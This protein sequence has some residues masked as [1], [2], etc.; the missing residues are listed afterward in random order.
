MNGRRWK[1][2]DV[3]LSA[4]LFFAAGAVLW[5]FAD[6]Y[7][8]ELE[9]PL[10][11]LRKLRNAIVVQDQVAGTRV[12]VSYAA[13]STP[14]YVIVLT[15]APGPDRVVAVSRLLPEGEF[16]TFR[17]PAERALAPGFYYAVLRADDG[18][19]LFDATKD[20]LVRD[21]RGAAS[22]TRFLLTDDRSP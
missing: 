22:L 2:S 20:G 19:G 17:V 6:A 10:T 1:L 12:V 16:H 5:L 11:S 4:S 14:S 18:D 13:L 8:P 9:S 21:A 7:D 3:L 15:E